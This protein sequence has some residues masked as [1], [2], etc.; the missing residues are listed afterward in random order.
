MKTSDIAQ[1][2]LDASGWGLKLYD[3]QRR[4][5]DDDSRFRIILKSRAVGGSFTIA[6]EALTLSLLMDDNTILLVSYSLRQ[7][8]EV[9]RRLRSLVSSLSKVSVAEQGVT[10]ILDPVVRETGS[11]LEFSNGSRVISLPN[12]PDAIRGYRADMVYVDEAGM[13][14]DDSGIKTAILLT[15]AARN[16]RITLVST[17]KGRRGW[18]YEAYKDALKKQT[19]SLHKIHYTM[20]RHITQNDVEGLRRTLSPLEWAQEMELEFLDE[21]NAV[22]PY[23]VI[24]SC[25]EDYEP[26]PADTDNP[27]Y[28]GIDFGR[29]RDS[30]VITAVE[31]T[32][33]KQRIVFLHEIHNQDFNTQ[34][35]SILSI[36]NMLNPVAVYVDKTGLGIPLYDMLERR[37]TGVVGVTMTA[38]VKEALIMTLSNMLHSRKIAIPSSAGKLINQLRMFRAKQTGLRLRYEAEAGEH[39]DYVISLAL[40]TYAAAKHGEDDVMAGVFWGW[41]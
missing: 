17:P 38:S 1:L 11:Y 7:S 19:W 15:T 37:A 10:Y 31:K 18:F 20:T 35:A 26:N 12:N 34:L 4:F 13:F 16:G 28:I 24:L 30:T 41:G 2:I 21:E 33:E 25:V 27:I 8:L 5:I 36:I 29:Y 22:F 14:R 3:W 9:F 40:A 23:E 32:K 6:L 39:D